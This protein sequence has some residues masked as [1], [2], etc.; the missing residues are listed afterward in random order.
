[1]RQKCLKLELEVKEKN[2]RELEVKI[3][4]ITEETN[5]DL[6]VDFKHERER[7]KLTKRMETLENEISSMRDLLREA[8]KELK[9]RD[10]EKVLK[11]FQ[12]SD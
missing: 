10:N 6:T 12:I 7:L 8:K 11:I 9:K 1:M 2:Q 3:P 5:F 4:R